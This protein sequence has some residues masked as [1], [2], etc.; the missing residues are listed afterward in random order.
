MEEKETPKIAT[1]PKPKKDAIKPYDKV[2]TKEVSKL[3]SIAVKE[4]ETTVTCPIFK[5]TNPFVFAVG[6]R[7]SS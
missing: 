4:L 6:V 3:Q 1:K 7:V 5:R 2:V